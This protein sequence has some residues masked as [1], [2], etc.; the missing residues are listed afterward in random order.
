MIR[1]DEEQVLYFRARRGHVAGP[2]AANAV[3]AARAVFGAQAQQ[4]GPGMLALSQRTRGRPTAEALRKQLLETRRLVRTW[5]QRETLHIYDPA[6]W[7]ALAAARAEWAP[8][9]RR[10]PM[11]TAKMLDRALGLFEQVGTTTR[12]DLL[13]VA[14]KSYERALLKEHGKYI[15]T[16][17]EARR[18][19]AGRL[20]WC[21][22]MRGDV[23]IADKIGTEQAYAARTVWFPDLKWPEGDARSAAT[24]LT[25]RY[26]S[27]NGPATT[28]DVAHFFGARMREA[29]CWIE[30]LQAEGEL[31]G[32]VCGNRKRLVILRK[33]LS[34]LQR[35]PPRAQAPWPVRLLPQWD[36]YL[37]GH[38]DKSWTVPDAGERKLVWRG[39]AVVAAGVI[40]RGRVVAEWQHE[41][42]RNR[43]QVT[44][45]PLSGWSKSKHMAGVH[46]EA[47]CVAAHLG[48]KDT[49]VR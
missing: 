46:R 1:V 39:Q 28:K 32:V 42:K 18:F 21:L 43:L 26:L 6:D 15:K 25:R 47:R 10:G 7:A 45:T 40:A 44:L 41:T 8:A 3:A 2:G 31:E 5:G 9:G 13:G 19:A 36:T 35:R 14:P 37:M 33:D 22:S 24:E 11:P 17:T 30:A 48:L 23:C 38:A 20:I 12:T 27:C 16:A 34:A 49:V 4:P 29:N